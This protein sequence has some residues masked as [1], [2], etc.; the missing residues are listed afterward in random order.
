MPL[1][2]F[3]VNRGSI[4]CTVK[5]SALIQQCMPAILLRMI[6]AQGIG[7]RAGGPYLQGRRDGDR[8]YAHKINQPNKRG[9]SV[10]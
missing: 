3:T 1:L 10:K 6:H 5:D 8:T 4:L 7:I 2:E 9:E